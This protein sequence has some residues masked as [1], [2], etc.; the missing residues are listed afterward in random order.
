MNRYR[1]TAPGREPVITECKSLGDLGTALKLVG[2]AWG[3]PW[4]SGVLPEGFRM[5]RIDSEGNEI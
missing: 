1:A 5:V 2:K 3:I 4:E